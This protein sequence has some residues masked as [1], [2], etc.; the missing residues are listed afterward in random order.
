MESISA[1]MSGTM[2]MERSKEIGIR[3][4]PGAQL[5]SLTRGVIGGL[6]LVGIGAAAGVAGS[7]VL[8]RAMAPLLF[9][10]M[11]YDPVIVRR[12]AGTADCICG[13]GRRT[14]PRAVRRA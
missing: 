6:G 9:G 8:S 14:S 12:G 10:V 5:G 11:P 4:A 13:V 2:V 3:I 1:A 7:L